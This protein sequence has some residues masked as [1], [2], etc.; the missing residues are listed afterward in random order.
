[1]RTVIPNLFKKFFIKLLLS[2]LPSRIT[3]KSILSFIRLLL[4]N[5]SEENC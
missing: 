5:L 4:C 1:M 3:V 2:S